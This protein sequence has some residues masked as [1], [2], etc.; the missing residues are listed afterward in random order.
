MATRRGGQPRSGKLSG[1]R[2]GDL[3]ARRMRRDLASEPGGLPVSM[4]YQTGTAPTVDRSFSGADY[5]GPG[6]GR[7]K[8]AKARS[9]RRARH[10]E[11]R[12]LAL[13]GD[14]SDVRRRTRA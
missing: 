5:G 10:V 1:N 7:V 11:E 13:G 12:K 4:D 9:R 14:Q 3:V 8:H 6:R 2:R